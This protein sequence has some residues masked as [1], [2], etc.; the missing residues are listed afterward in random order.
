MWPWRS[1][2]GRR[3]ASLSFKTG[4]S[5]SQSSR[6]LSAPDR[7]SLS[8]PHGK[9]RSASYEARHATASAR[10]DPR[11]SSRAERRRASWGLLETLVFRMRNPPLACFSDSQM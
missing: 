7:A 8:T 3:P 6:A 9:P 2:N 4:C 5:F 11:T 1:A 10:L